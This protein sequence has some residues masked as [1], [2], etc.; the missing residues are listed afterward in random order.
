MMNENAIKTSIAVIQTQMDTFG[1]NQSFLMQ[2]ISS[3]K[4]LLQTE[5]KD[6]RGEF[7]GHMQEQSKTNEIRVK[8]LS[9]NTEQKIQ[10]LKKEIEDRLKEKA[11][12]VS[13]QFTHKIV[14]GVVSMLILG[15]ANELFNLI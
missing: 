9:L 14:W 1:K 5:L 6:I 2:E 7:H 3:I 13:Y 4:T 15:I 10:T 11:D 12:N 8:E